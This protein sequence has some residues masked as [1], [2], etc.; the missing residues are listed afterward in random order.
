MANDLIVR[1]KQV[2]ELGEWEFE[3]VD[4]ERWLPQRKFKGCVEKVDAYGNCLICVSCRVK[5]SNNR[6]VDGF[7]AHKNEILIGLG[8]D[9][10]NTEKPVWQQ[11]N[12]RHGF[13]NP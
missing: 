4:C 10:Y 13:P 8:Y 11:F 1:R 12:E 9:P 3:C 2:N 5:N 7:T 6:R